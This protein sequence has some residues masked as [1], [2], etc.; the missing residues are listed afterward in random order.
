[1]PVLLPPP[2]APFAAPAQ[3]VLDVPDVDARL[4][5]WHPA[6]AAAVRAAYDDPAVRRWHSRAIESDAEAAET[7]TRW[8]TGWSEGR[9]A[10]WAVAGRGDGLLGRVAVKLYDPQ[11]VGVI[12]YWT[13]PAARGRGVAPAALA[14]ASAWAFGVGFH[15]LEL[16][17]S[18]ANAASCRVAQKA[19]F[20]AEGVLRGAVRHT[21]GWHDMHLHARTA[22]DGPPAD[23][24]TRR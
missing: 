24:G 20:A 22:A 11:G 15:R 16:A 18:T 9:E 4:R 6:D 12:A 8:R 7:V 5:P 17:H 21:D 14:V 19:G 13:V 1:M 23:L 2:F 3:P 10:G